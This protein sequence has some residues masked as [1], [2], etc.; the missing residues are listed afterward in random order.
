MR[1][2]LPLIIVLAT[3]LA[4]PAS[5]AKLRLPVDAFPG[6]SAHFDL[7]SGGAIGDFLCGTNT[8]NGHQGTDYLTPTG[9]PLKAAADGNQY[10]NYDGCPTGFFGSGCGGGF[11]N[12]VRIQHDNAVTVSAH[13]VS[14]TP[15][16]NGAKSC[17]ASIGQ[18]GSS[19]NVTG[20]H[21]HFELDLSTA[22]ADPR[23][24]YHGGCSTTTTSPWWLSQS[25]ASAGTSCPVVDPVLAISSTTDQADF[26][27]E[28]ASKNIPDALEGDT[29]TVQIT[30]EAKSSG[31]PAS[32]I[33]VNVSTQSPWLTVQGSSAINFG[34]FTSGQKKT[35]SVTIKAV[36]YSLGEVDHP[37][38]TA[39]IAGT[40]KKTTEQVDVFGAHHWEWAGGAQETEGWTALTD[41]GEVKVNTA[42][43]CLAADQNGSAPVLRSPPLAIKA[44]DWAGFDLRV[45]QYAGEQ[46]ARLSWVTSNAPDWD[47]ANSVPFVLDSSDEFAVVHVEVSGHP[48]WQGTVTR[49]RLQTSSGP[50]GWFDMDYL[51]AVEDSAP[52]SGNE[53]SDPAVTSLD[54]DDLNPDI[55][56]GAPELCDALD[57][58][59][60]EAADEGLDIGATCT[61]GAGI[62]TAD[63]VLECSDLAVVCSV[64]PG[65]PTDETCNGLDD[66]CD[67]QTDEDFGLGDPCEAGQANCAR[68]GT[69]VCTEDGKGTV[70][71]APPTDPIPE[72]CNGIDDDCDGFTDEDFP[73]LE[74]CATGVGACLAEGFW[75]CAEDG[76]AFCKAPVPDGIAEICDAIDNDCDGLVDEGFPAGEDCEAERP[77]C[78]IPGVWTCDPTGT[79][80]LCVADFETCQDAP[81]TTGSGD[82]GTDSASG[83]TDGS[84][85]GTT[86]TTTTSSTGDGADGEGEGEGGGTGQGA[87][88]TLAAEPPADAGCGHAP[89]PN[90]GGPA[91]IVFTLLVLGTLGRQ[92]CRVG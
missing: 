70:C 36:Q 72:Q 29:F 42:S 55:Y 58:D 8:Y 19:G 84:A 27:P 25:G 62:C 85:A 50:N 63:G 9:T 17:G 44:Q 38:V 10:Q 26:R 32:G 22:L 43:Q 51:R 21:L 16:G 37:D 39:T 79:E 83:S 18:S 61:V 24:P 4:Q 3:C 54:C 64:A 75:A 6:V 71:A 65:Q 92:R 7:K 57:N 88:T 60:D 31:G 2:T 90:N 23:D 87:A 81:A 41:I 89:S 76:E 78:F 14:G 59:C 67:G 52:T 13:M 45:R 73:L 49:L 20:P 86:G 35:K 68:T 15:S 48:Q 34:N 33:T 74:D 56:A 69:L 1:R 5:A 30:V 66:D 40:N 80:V 11:G 12:N 46:S 77:D 53:D 47:I 91:A 28:G 82:T